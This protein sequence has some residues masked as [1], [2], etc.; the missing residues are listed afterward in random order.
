M[1]PRE[2]VAPD[3]LTVLGSLGLAVDE[4]EQQRRVKLANWIASPQH[5]LTARVWVNRAWERFFGIGIGLRAID[6]VHQRHH[7]QAQIV[8]CAHHR[9]AGVGHGG[10]ARFADQPDVLALQGGG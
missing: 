9:A 1:Q 5:P 6:L 10:H 8:R 7:A 4:P 2:V 3:A